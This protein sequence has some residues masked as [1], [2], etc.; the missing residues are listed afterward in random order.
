MKRGMAADV[1]NLYRL[2][3]NEFTSARNA[4]AKTLS[5]TEK[6]EVASLVKPSL[7]MWAVNQ[8]YWQDRPTYDALTNASEKLRA[9]HKA[10]LSGR[11]ADTRQPDQLHRTTLERAFS[12]AVEIAGRHGVRLTDAARD[13]LRQALSA[14]PADEP[15]GRHTHAPEPAGFSLLTGITPRPAAARHAEP[16][17]TATTKRNRHED[18]A[19]RQRAE[20]ERR[21]A[22][23]RARREAA[24]AL[25]TQERERKQR[26]KR[27]RE[28]QRA[29]QVLREAE[30]RLA[31]LKR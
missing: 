30:R 20:R 8:L 23:R 6:K 3:L 21:E 9:A 22:E 25:K 1:D 29:E 17:A 18:E 12:R 26:E 28:I 2:P 11:K 5:G 13:T 27:E 24:A 4:L 16:P 7:P 19:A 31:E 15:A 10:I 14:L